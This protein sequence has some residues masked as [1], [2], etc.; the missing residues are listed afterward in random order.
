MTLKIQT[1]WYILRQIAFCVLIVGVIVFVRLLSFYFGGGQNL[2][3]I[4]PKLIEIKEN[5]VFF[6]KT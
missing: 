6:Q 2:F 4:W 1:F 3:D 5:H